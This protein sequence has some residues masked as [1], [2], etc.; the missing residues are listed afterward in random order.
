MSISQ[1]VFAEKW[2]VIFWVAGPYDQH[3]RVTLSHDQGSGSLMGN[4]TF[5]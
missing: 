2:A 1:L 5:G 4:I 3:V